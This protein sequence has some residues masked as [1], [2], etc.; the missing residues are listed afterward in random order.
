MIM[1]FMMAAP[2]GAAAGASPDGRP[3][4]APIAQ[5]VTPQSRGMR[6]GISS[7]MRSACSLP[8]EM[9]SGGASNIWDLTGDMASPAVVKAL[10]RT[11]FTMGG[12]MFHGNVTDVEELLRAQES[13]EDYP[14]MIVRVGGFSA[15]FVGLD[16]AMQ[17]ELIH[18]RRHTA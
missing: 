18:R 17:D 4:G 5:G 2:T 11:F 3:A 10:L 8:L 12:Q 15:R 1:S 13:P 9:F 7:A 6:D 16:R 14:H